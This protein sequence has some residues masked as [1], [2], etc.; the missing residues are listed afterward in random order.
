MK[1]E[2]VPD[3]LFH[4]AHIKTF[5]KKTYTYKA[6]TEPWAITK[7]RNLLT[8][9]VII[10]QKLNNHFISKMRM[11]QSKKKTFLLYRITT[12]FIYD[13]LLKN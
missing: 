3:Q 4:I 7:R 11:C 12:A 8:E 2:Q 5:P 13:L 6:T 10:L 1:T 9:K